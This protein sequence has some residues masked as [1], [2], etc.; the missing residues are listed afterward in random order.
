MC[1]NAVVIFLC[2]SF[3][4]ITVPIEFNS[5][6]KPVLSFFQGGL[7]FIFPRAKKSSSSVQP[8]SASMAS[9][10]I[11]IISQT[12]PVDCNK[13]V[14]QSR[15]GPHQCRVSPSFSSAMCLLYGTVHTYVIKLKML[16]ITVL[17]F[18]VFQIF[19]HW[20]FDTEG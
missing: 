16:F 1:N 12:S 5:S 9:G 11:Y 17:V 3:D 13:V 8:S 6:S 10:W 14:S 15:C 19:F 20:N 7:F 4:H 18:H 2:I